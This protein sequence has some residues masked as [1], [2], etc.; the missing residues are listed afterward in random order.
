MVLAALD[1][2]EAE[3]TRRNLIEEYAQ[4]LLDECC[5]ETDALLVWRLVHLTAVEKCEIAQGLLAQYMA[6]N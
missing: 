4:L 3:I 1:T 5:A 6:V 2:L